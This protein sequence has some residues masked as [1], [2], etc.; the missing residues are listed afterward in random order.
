ME[1]YHIWVYHGE[2]SEFRIQDDIN[3]DDDDEYDNKDG[4][5]ENE[6][7]EGDGVNIMIEDAFQGSHIDAYPRETSDDH[8]PN[9][10]IEGEVEDYDRLL[11]ETQRE[12]YSGCK[13]FSKRKKRER[14]RRNLWFTSSLRSSCL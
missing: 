4:M 11:R 6:E 3:E 5:I 1:S 7:I 2:S 14:E 8:S 13:K 10:M 12:L 9:D